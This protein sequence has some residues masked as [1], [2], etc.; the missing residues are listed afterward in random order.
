M[1]LFSDASRLFSQLIKSSKGR[2]KVCGL[3]QY[4]SD[5][6]H[7]CHKYSDVLEIQNLYHSNNIRSAVIA[8]ELKSQFSQGRK[9]FRLFKFVG[10]VSTI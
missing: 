1:A 6:Y 7:S 5:F 8:L 2:D 10:Q 9:I 3:L 4:L